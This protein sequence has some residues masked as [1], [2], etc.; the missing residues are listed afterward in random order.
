MKMTV[1]PGKRPGLPKALFN[2]DLR[3]SDIEINEAGAVTVTFIGDDIYTKNATQRFS[4]TLS[5]N[6]IEMVVEAIGLDF[7]R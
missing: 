4:I 5:Q 1:Q 3:M 7:G 2:R 6:E